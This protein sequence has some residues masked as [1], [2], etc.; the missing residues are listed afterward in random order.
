MSLWGVGCFTQITDETPL[1]VQPREACER[2]GIIILNKNI[3]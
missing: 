3:S 2:H 1:T